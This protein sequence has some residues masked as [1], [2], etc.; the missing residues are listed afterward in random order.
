MT[1]PFMVEACDWLSQQSDLDVVVL[2]GHWDIAGSGASPEMAMPQWYTEMAALPGCSE[3][4]QR[5]MLKFVMGHTHCNDPH[6]HGKVGAGFR[7][8]GFGMEGCG[9]FGMPI[10]DTTEGRVRFWYFDTSSDDM[11]N[12][13]IACVTQKGWRSCTSLA[14][15]WLDQPIAPK[16]GDSNAGHPE[17]I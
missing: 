15:S 3:F 1:M 9:N 4:D 5:G 6:P 12:K 10:I 14:T 11:F 16:F 2:F 13:T 8:A 7:V 17:F